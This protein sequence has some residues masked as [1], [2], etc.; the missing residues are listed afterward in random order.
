MWS[1]EGAEADGR[2]AQAN[3]CFE[4]AATLL[5]N[6]DQPGRA[7]AAQG[8]LLWLKLTDPTRE[9]VDAARQEIREGMLEGRRGVDLILLARHFDIEFNDAPLRYYLSQRSRVGGLVGQ[10]LVA[11]IFL[12]ERSMA[13]RDYAEFLEYEENRFSQIVPKSTLAGMRGEALVRDGQIIK[14]RDILEA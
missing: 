1:L 14:A 10:E 11:E 12:V 13:P 2:Q 5:I 8:W 7:H 3:T 9:V 6:I 4:K